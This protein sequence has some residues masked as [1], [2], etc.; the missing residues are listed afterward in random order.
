MILGVKSLLVALRPVASGVTEDL[1]LAFYEKLFRNLDETGRYGRYEA[2]RHAL[3]QIRSRPNRDKC[4][5]SR[6]WANAL[7][8]VD[9][10]TLRK[11]ICDN[12]YGFDYL[13]IGDW[14]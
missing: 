11:H 4:A 5:S 8:N 13:L 6:G 2:Y 3:N 1:F 7:F 9:S 10:P 14:R 12:Y